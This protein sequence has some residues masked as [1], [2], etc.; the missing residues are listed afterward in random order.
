MLTVYRPGTANV[1]QNARIADA[2]VKYQST[3]LA[4]LQVLSDRLDPVHSLPVSHG[5]PAGSASEALGSDQIAQLVKRM[6]AL[7]KGEKSIRTQVE[8]V[9]DDWGVMSEEWKRSS[10][11]VFLFGE[12]QESAC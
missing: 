1:A 5:S 12:R 6:E 8:G 2:L 7:E 9:Q 3:L 4:N 11:R 10:V